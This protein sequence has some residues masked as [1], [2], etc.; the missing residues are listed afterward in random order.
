MSTVSFQQLVEK[1]TMISAALQ[2]E[3]FSLDIQCISFCE[4]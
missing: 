4:V 2:Y 1:I 3:L